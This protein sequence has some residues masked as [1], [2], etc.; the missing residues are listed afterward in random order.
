MFQQY[1]DEN[2]LTETQFGDAISL[3][4]NILFSI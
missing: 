2:A 3:C 4:S 1:D